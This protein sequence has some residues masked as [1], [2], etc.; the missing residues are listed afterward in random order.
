MP[1]L[2]VNASRVD[3]FRNFKFGVRW[4][5]RYVAAVSSVSA[6][7]RTTDVI[8]QRE[9]GDP[10]ATHRMPGRTTYEPVTL[11]RGVTHDPEFEQ[12]ANKVA[13]AGPGAGSAGPL[14][15]FRRDVT[16]ELF[17]DAGRAVMSYTIFRCWPSEYVAVSSL[18]VHT[19][20][21][22][23]ERLTL[24]NE[25][26]RRDPDVGAPHDPAVDP[27]SPTIGGGG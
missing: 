14:E 11:E 22:P 2:P 19:N 1:Q 12:W 16:I 20:V 23:V 24:E 25:G 3:P 5:G 21:A 6:L 26:W 4:D 27:R 8:E 13:G 17:D 7:R 18:D 10:T 9:G 15:D